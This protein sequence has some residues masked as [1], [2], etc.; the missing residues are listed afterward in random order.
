MTP[1]ERVRLFLTAMTQWE[2]T[3]VRAVTSGTAAEKEAIRSSLQAIYEEHLSTKGKSAARFG[4][5]LVG[6]GPSVQDPPKFD[7]EVA[8]TESGPK[9]GVVY[10]TAK[11]RK[12]P[13]TAW[14]FTVVVD[15]KG[16]A[17][18]DDLHGAPMRNGE[19]VGEW[20]KFGY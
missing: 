16:D 6:P 15:A 14:R 2:P 4:R 18:I 13:N 5:N 12:D 19:V 10:V 3:A 7:Q 1:E 8:K 17:K 9:K 11:P 20:A